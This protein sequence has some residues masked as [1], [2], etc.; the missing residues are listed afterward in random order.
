MLTLPL[1]FD[2]P[3][4]CRCGHCKNAAPEVKKAARA[5]KGVANIGVVDGDKA[6]AV[7]QKLGVKGFPTFKLIVDGKVSDYNGGRDANAM[8]G[9]VMKE[10][11]ELVRGRM[12]GKASGSSGS[13]SG[14]KKASGGSG[15]GGNSNEPGHGKHVIKGTA[16]NFDKEVLNAAEPVLVEFYAPW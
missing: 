4:T 9:A 14:S 10:V 12:G 5:L 2:M 6:G 1:P 15:S 16:A 8:V 11:Q 7:A 3:L 13:G